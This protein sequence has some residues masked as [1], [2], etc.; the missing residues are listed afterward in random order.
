MIAQT[1]MAWDASSIS[2]VLFDLDGTL[3]DSSHLHS[4]A[5]REALVAG[6]P[7]LLAGFNYEQ[8]KGVPTHEVFARLGV[9]DVERRRGLTVLKQKNYRAAVANGQLRLFPGA[10]ELLVAM[11]ERGFGLYVVTGSSAD[12]AKAALEVSGLAGLLDGVVTANDVSHGKPAPDCYLECLSQFGLM[13]RDCVVVEDAKDGVAAARAAILQV[14]GVHDLAIRPL[15]DWWAPDLAAL[16]S[17]FLAKLQR[18]N[19]R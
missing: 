10:R 18:S 2:H 5:Y 7:E 1:P 4:R 9:A 16:D 6:A 11:G 8:Y 13:A 14:W 19:E 17:G 3:I 12:S 15:C